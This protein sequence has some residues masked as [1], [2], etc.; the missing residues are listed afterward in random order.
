MKKLKSNLSLYSYSRLVF[1]DTH[2]KN[3][4]ELLFEVLKGPD[5]GSL[6]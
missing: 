4:Q 5:C 2:V 6:S 3:I 1:E